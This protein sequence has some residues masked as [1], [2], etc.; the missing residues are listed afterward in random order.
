M[1]ML[2][3]GCWLSWAASCFVLI[4]FIQRANS[5]SDHRH[6]ISALAFVHLQQ[7]YSASGGLPVQTFDC[8][9]CTQ[10]HAFMA[11]SSSGR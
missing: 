7:F 6:V 11:V 4:G 5:T 3:A 2:T 10:H 8:V 1:Q 9:H